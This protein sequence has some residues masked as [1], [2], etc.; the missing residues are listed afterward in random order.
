VSPELLQVVFVCAAFW[1]ALAGYCLRERD[2]ALRQRAIVGLVLGALAAYAGWALLHADTLARAGWSA[3]LAVSSASLLFVPF[4]VL[5]AA[6]R[7]GDPRRTRHL[8]A[9]FAALPLA[10]A[11]ARVGCVLRGCCHGF[12]AS[13]PWGVAHPALPAPVLP[14]PLYDVAGLLLLFAVARRLAPEWIAPAVLVGLGL[15]RLALEPLRAPDPA[16]PWLPV[17]LVALAL[18]AAGV[19]LALRRPST[20]LAPTGG[21]KLAL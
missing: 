15:L 2:P 18:V 3:A 11:V 8:A 14:V 6:P 19:A 1:V 17:E 16:P 9:S 12:A 4:G 21:T 13:P 10:L 5:A 7:R 20:G